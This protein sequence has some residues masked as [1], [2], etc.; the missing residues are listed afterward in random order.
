[1]L[2]KKAKKTKIFCISMQRTG[3]T[4]VGQFFKNQNFKVAD[5]GISHM[6]KWSY[7]WEEGDFETIFNS[8]DF[9]NNQVYED[10]P[11]WLPE[12]YKILYHRFPNSKFILFTRN[13]DDWFNSMVSHSKGKIPGNTKRH[14]K[15]YRRETDFYNL[16]SEPKE[17]IH[18]NEMSIDNL[19][20]LR[21][22]EKH[23]KDIYRIRNQEIK[24]FFARKKSDA[25][26]TCEL[27]DPE[28]WKK[29]G[30]FL[31]LIVPDDFEIHK[32]K[33]SK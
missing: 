17:R 14:C 8:K 3:T 7:Y 12:F 1:M 16:F 21:G 20:E 25:L 27:E 2:F 24:D 15:V 23:Y 9:R 30:Q 22:Y 32:N 18:Y 13:E 26:F 11:W 28:K 33:S 10:S 19:L 29:L 5:W 4:S 31:N 6:N